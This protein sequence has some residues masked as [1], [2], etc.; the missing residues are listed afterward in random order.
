MLNEMWRQY[1]RALIKEA[2]DVMNRDHDSKALRTRIENFVYD[3][4]E[5]PEDTA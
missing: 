5:T 2:T 1:D 3:N 4:G